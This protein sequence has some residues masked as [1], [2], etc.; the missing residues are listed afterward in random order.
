M[1]TPQANVLELL[2]GRWRSQTLYAGV[3]LGVF[4]VIGDKPVSADEVASALKLNPEL[5]YRLL[6]ALASLRL[7]GED[8]DRGFSL[9]GEG[10]LLR[11][12]DPHSM[13]D[14]IL[15]REGP[16]HTAVWKHLTEI[17]RDG[18]QDGFV[19]EFGQSAFDYA[20]HQPSYAAAFDAGMS[21]HSHLQTDWVIEAL[22][23]HNF[24][25]PAHLCD[26]GGGQ[27]HLLSHLL[28]RY[29]RLI[30][31]I[32]ER[33]S[34]PQQTQALW[35][36]R[37]GVA[38]RCKYVT[39]DMFVD[40]PAADAYIMKMV[41]HDWSDDECVHILKNIHRRAAAS[42]SVFIA[43]HVIPEINTSNFA[44][45]FDIH[46]MCWGRARERTVP[47]Y[48]EILKQAGWNYV[49]T[50]FPAGGVIGVVEGAKA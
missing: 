29:P 6:R 30:G 14:V 36:E 10:E 44:T 1:S 11:S 7:L 20:A 13:R 49:A 31:T 43:E 23:R 4:D 18:K 34:E 46:M 15:L 21:S 45:L 9:T 39:G 28:L 22:Q 16:E 38:D 47:E 26:V 5:T 3:K 24:S 2:Y 50:W 48:V 40:V 27:G 35:A 42:G 25:S 19:R 8:A 12:D 32:L 41:L 37:L 33:P 17:V